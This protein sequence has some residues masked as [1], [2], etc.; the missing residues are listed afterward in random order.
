MG[1]NRAAK[2]YGVPRFTLKNRMSGK[3]K[4]SKITGPKLYR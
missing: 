1:V 2:E 4:H 3:I